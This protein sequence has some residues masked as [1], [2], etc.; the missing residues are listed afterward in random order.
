MRGRASLIQKIYQISNILNI[1]QP[2]IVDI[3]GFPDRHRR[4]A[5]LVQ[6]TDQICDILYIHH[7]TVVDVTAEIGTGITDTVMVAVGL[8]GIGYG[9]AIVAQIADIVTVTIRLIRVRRERTIV[10]CI[11]NAI[12]I[13]IVTIALIGHTVVVFVK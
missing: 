13:K 7:A 5:T 8:I 10:I 11:E 1:D 3:T 4:R 12:S 9:R 2:G 6:V